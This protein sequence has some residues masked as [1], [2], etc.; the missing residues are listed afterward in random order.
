MDFGIY[1]R[2]IGVDGSLAKMFDQFKQ[3][4]GVVYPMSAQMRLLIDMFVT[5]ESRVFDIEAL[6]A[7]PLFADLAGGCV[8]SIPTVYRD[9]PRL[10]PGVPL[11]EG[12]VGHQGLH[13]V[14]DRRLAEAHVDF[15]TTVGGLFG[16]HEG[17]AIGPNPKYHGRPSYHPILARLAENDRVVAAELRPGDRGFGGNDVPFIERALDRVRAEIGSNCILYARIDG[18]GDCAEVMRCIDA[19]GAFFLTKARMSHDLIYCVAYQTTW[20]TVDRDAMGRP[21][22]QVAELR[23]QR[24]AWKDIGL[25]VRAFAV[26]SRD[27]DIGKQIYLWDDNDFSVQV[28]LTNDFSSEADDLAWRYNQR[29]GIEP[30]IGELK[31]N[32]GIGDI[33]C[34]SFD[35]NHAMLLLKLLTYN[36]LRR[37]VEDRAPSIRRWRAKWIRRV[38]ICRPCRMIRSGR[39]KSIRMA[40]SP[41]L[42]N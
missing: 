27:R 36:L 32:W 10:A 5:G 38:L 42:L 34:Y 29:A 31:G 2:S 20:N 3:G 13:G 30:L 7:D 33:P 21:T 1:L 41:V 28:Y 16:E 40:P 14:G 17:G 11:L 18:A 15:D 25:Q 23:F 12:M 9:L 19:K 6:A 39:R 37:Y 22:R 4:P 35:A 8:P 24:E 26:R